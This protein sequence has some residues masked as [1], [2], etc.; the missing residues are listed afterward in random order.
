[1]CCCAVT[2]IAL[3]SDCSGSGIAR[4]DWKLTDDQRA[5]LRDY[6]PPD[7]FSVYYTEASMNPTTGVEP[8]QGTLV[9]FETWEYYGAGSQWSFDNGAMV[10]RRDIAEPTQTVEYSKLRPEQFGSGMSLSQISDVIGAE[11]DRDIDMSISDIEGV[12]G[13]GW[14][15][16]VVTVLQGDQ[17]VSIQTF[18]VPKGGAQ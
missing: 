11:P 12:T 8:E 5:V 13:Y 14:R 2:S 10:A 1:M 18:P 3:L 6:G 15:G 7:T 16:Q 17:M 9:R 4:Q